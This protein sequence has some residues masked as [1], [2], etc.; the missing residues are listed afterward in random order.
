MKQHED[1]ALE[2]MDGV[3]YEVTLARAEQILETTRKQLDM[4]QPLDD[5]GFYILAYMVWRMKNEPDDSHKYTFTV[6]KLYEQFGKL[7]DKRWSDSGFVYLLERQILG[8]PLVIRSG[9]RGMKTAEGVVHWLE[10]DP[11]IVSARSQAKNL[12]ELLA[13]IA[14]LRP[15]EFIPLVKYVDGTL[16]RVR[17]LED[18]T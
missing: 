12:G 3:P 6:P 13:S 18:K 5:P 9:D 16:F 17:R 4:P 1:M 15:G 2:W 8:Q 10:N 14:V 11:L 7:L